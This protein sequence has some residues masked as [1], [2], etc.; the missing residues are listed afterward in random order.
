MPLCEAQATGSTKSC[1]L[2][3]SRSISVVTPASIGYESENLG[4]ATAKVGNSYD[5]CLWRSTSL[6]EKKGFTLHSAVELVVE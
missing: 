5:Y 3:L 6:A 1:N 2:Q 4:I